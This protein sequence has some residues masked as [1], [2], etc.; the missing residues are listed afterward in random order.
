MVDRLS[1]LSFGRLLSGVSTSEVKANLIRLIP[2]YAIS[3]HD[4]QVAF[5]RSQA[6]PLGWKTKKNHLVN[7]IRGS[8]VPHDIALEH[9]DLGDPSFAITAFGSE[10]A[11]PLAGLLLDFA[12]SDRLSLR[13]YFGFSSPDSNGGPFIRYGILK[14]IINGKPFRNE[15]EL[16]ESLHVS[17]YAIDYHLPDLGSQ[18][19]IIYRGRLS[20]ELYSDFSWIGDIPTEQVSTYG[21]D[22]VL[23]S[24]VADLLR[25]ESDHQWNIPEVQEALALKGLPRSNRTRINN[26]LRFLVAQ[27]LVRQGELSKESQFA[28][29][30]TPEQGQAIEKLVKLMEDF[31]EQDGN[32]IDRG[33][34]MSQGISSQVIADVLRKAHGF[35]N[36]AKRITDKTPVN[37]FLE[38]VSKYPGITTAQLCEVL[39]RDYDRHVT[40][41]TAQV[42]LKKLREKGKLI[43]DTEKVAIHWRMP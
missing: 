4:L 19:V 32:V 30:L 36:A 2:A 22:V 18:N 38:I 40:R 16:A 24:R 14:E 13:N 1:D 10:K 34:V 29:S 41:V 33:Y 35:S 43:A 7:H 11:V 31:R 39:K 15:Q 3:D 23:T 12:S 37:P 6:R 9:E 8:L 42:A 27:N 28:I 20:E 25:D 17:V 5:T 21:H 26:I